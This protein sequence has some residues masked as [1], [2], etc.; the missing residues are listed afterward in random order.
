MIRIQSGRY[1]PEMQGDTHQKKLRVW[2]FITQSI[3][4]DIQQEY[5]EILNRKA[6]LDLKSR[7]HRA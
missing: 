7:R 2:T 5:E 4:F 1:G 6:K 3:S